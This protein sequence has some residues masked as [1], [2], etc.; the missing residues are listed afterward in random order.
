VNTLTNP[1]TLEHLGKMQGFGP[2]TLSFELSPTPPP[3]EMV[4]NIHL[5]PFVGN[6]CVLIE[7]DWGNKD[8]SRFAMP[9][10]T[11]EPGETWR[12]AA[13]RELVE[14]AGARV[15]SITPFAFLRGHTSSPD[16]YRPHLP[17]PDFF[18]VIGWAE[19]ELV[20]DPLNPDDGEHVVDV[21]CTDVESAARTFEDC[22]ELW[23]ADAYRL[24]AYLRSNA[25]EQPANSNR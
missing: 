14:E 21:R 19:V 8:F 5:V 20:G 25:C 24:A 23:T 9:G 11:L 3:Q 22:G 2:V 16:P 6:R 10:G 12:Q 17:H 13:H 15:L 4:S 18:W 1:P 7:V